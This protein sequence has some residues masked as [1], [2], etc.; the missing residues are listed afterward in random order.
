M[1]NKKTVASI[2]KKLDRLKKRLADNRDDLRGLIDEYEMLK[3]DCE[4][5]MHLLDSAADSLSRFL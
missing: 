5:A 2:S 1:V 3:D 4:E